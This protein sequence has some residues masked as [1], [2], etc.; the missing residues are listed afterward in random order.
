MKPYTSE[1]VGN[2]FAWSDDLDYLVLRPLSHTQPD[3]YHELKD[4]I[5]ERVIRYLGWSIQKKG[6][7][8]IGADM[9]QSWSRAPST[10]W[11]N[12]TSSP[13]PQAGCMLRSC[14]PK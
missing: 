6:T 11:I 12:A 7:R 13:P 5:A 1:D 10:T 3:R 8:W 14:M 2:F 4:R 9:R